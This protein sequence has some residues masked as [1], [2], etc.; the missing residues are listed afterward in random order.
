MLVKSERARAI[1]RTES[2]LKRTAENIEALRCAVAGRKPRAL[3]IKVLLE[4]AKIAKIPESEL[5]FFFHCINSLA[6]ISYGVAKRDKLWQASS[7]L[8]HS[9]K[10]IA[11][12]ARS[13]ATAIEEASDGAQEWVRLSLHP[14]VQVHSTSSRAWRKGWLTPQARRIT[15]TTRGNP[16]EL[17]S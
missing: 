9:S 6:V 4:I 11:A 15:W 16:L 5:V 14:R 10:R 8:G 12:A 17:F 1:E 7:D 3:D 13:L 2:E